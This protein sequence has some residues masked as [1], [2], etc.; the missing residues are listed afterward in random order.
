MRSDVLTFGREIMFR[1]YNN[2]NLKAM[3]FIIKH[4]THKTFS[5]WD[6]VQCDVIFLNSYTFIK[7]YNNNCK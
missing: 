1:F 6:S 7:Y 2:I 5:G 3:V 4:G